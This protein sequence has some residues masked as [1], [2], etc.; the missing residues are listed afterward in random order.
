MFGF[1]KRLQINNKDKIQHMINNLT[2]DPQK[3]FYMFMGFALQPLPK[4]RNIKFS[5]PN[6]FNNI[7]QLDKIKKDYLNY[8]RY[9][10]YVFRR[11]IDLIMIKTILNYFYNNN[12]VSVIDWLFDTITY[13]ITSKTEKRMHEL[14]DHYAKD[15]APFTEFM[16]AF[17]DKKRAVAN[18][19]RRVDNEKKRVDNERKR[20]DKAKQNAMTKNR[21]AKQEKDLYYELLRMTN[22]NCQN[23]FDKEHQAIIDKINE[24]IDY[25]KKLKA[26]LHK[27][28]NKNNPIALLTRNDRKIEKIDDLID[29]QIA[30]YEGIIRVLSHKTNTNVTPLTRRNNSTNNLP[31]L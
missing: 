13:Q 7:T 23:F 4:N 19:K 6:N 29:N 15:L 31:A 17:K 5:I 26:I 25:F 2:L 16:E 28:N 10:D 21:L 30:L 18:E 22:N 24:V 14:I 1:G 20:V 9:S 27:N 8:S 3:I 12:T 11:Y